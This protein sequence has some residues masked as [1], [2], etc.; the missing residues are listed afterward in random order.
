MTY[1]EYDSTHLISEPKN[2]LDYIWYYN[3]IRF[4]EISLDEIDYDTLLKN[5]TVLADIKTELLFKTDDN[6]TCLQTRIKQNNGNMKYVC[7]KYCVLCGK[8]SDAICK[9]DYRFITFQMMLSRTIEPHRVLYVKN[10]KKARINTL[11]TNLHPV[12]QEALTT[13]PIWYIIYKIEVKI[14]AIELKTMQK[15]NTSIL[16]QYLPSDIVSKIASE[17]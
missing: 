5:V 2:I 7:D 13:N 6:G 8:D 15:T 4:T 3:I 17:I 1:Y 16:E 11:I 10:N 14:T 12:I 9:F